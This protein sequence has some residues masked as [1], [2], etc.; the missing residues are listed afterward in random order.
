MRTSVKTI[1]ALCL[2]ALFLL[3]CGVYVM[4]DNTRTWTFAVKIEWDDEGHEDS[5]PNTSFNVQILYDGALYREVSFPSQ[6]AGDVWEDLIT[7]CEMG[8]ENSDERT[9]YMREHYTVEPDD[10]AGYRYD[11][12]YI[13][14]PYYRFQITYTYIGTETP[15]AD[16]SVTIG[17][18]VSGSIYSAYKVFDV[19]YNESHTAFSYTIDRNNP[20]FEKVQAASSYFE[21]TEIG[22]SG[23]YNVKMLSAYTGAAHDTAP[24]DSQNTASQFAAD[25]KTFISG[26]NWDSSNYF[27]TEKKNY[28]TVTAESDNQS[29]LTIT[30][31]DPGYYF[32]STTTGTLCSLDTN[33]RD[34]II[35]DKNQKPTITKQVQENST[36][37]FGATNDANIGDTV[38]FRVTIN[39]KQGAQDY[40]L[41]DTL[42]N[43]SFVEV[44]QVTKNGDEV[45]DT[46][47]YS[48]QAAEDHKSFTVDFSD[49]FESGIASG[50][51][52]VVTY[53]ATIDE[54]A[55]IAGEGNLNTVVLHY[56]ANNS[57]VQQQ[58]RTFVWEIDIFKYT[59]ASKTGLSNAKFVFSTTNDV[60]GG[61]HL[62]GTYP[63]FLFNSNSEGDATVITTD[64]TG[65]FNIKGLDAG[66]YY[67]FE[68]EAP[69]GYNQLPEPIQITISSTVD[70]ND[71]TK[72]TV[73]VIPALNTSGELEIENQSGTVLPS[74]GGV[75]TT[76]YYI[77]GGLL[78]VGATLVLARFQKKSKVRK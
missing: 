31:L 68:T 62:N 71:Q 45:A 60:S 42:T 57:T 16:A 13:G 3:T 22:N 41:Y 72:R 24:T 12:E 59:G 14:S 29:G 19:T 54:T 33:D 34:I 50:D 20:F 1:L 76:G 32:V 11:V 46:T 44:T 36:G 53:K 58:T 21:L 37:A 5:R 70:S 6:T 78:A 7:N 66:T 65:K 28:G 75:G 77:F 23:V 73:S 15:Q 9:V 64:N 51:E 55:V 35:Y 8:G 18:S 10:L 39:A 48:V 26:D 2:L 49:S 30:D 38:V 27:T 17:N 74:T 4:A 63:D 40:I 52:I 67:L 61:V 43:M 56:G 25:L 69:A 47:A